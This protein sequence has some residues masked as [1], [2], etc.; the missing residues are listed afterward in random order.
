MQWCGVLWGC[1]SLL[2]SVVK[3]HKVLWSVIQCCGVKYSVIEG[4]TVF[5]SA[6]G[7]C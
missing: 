1:I 7:C 6:I 5:R 4:N 2:W 3:H